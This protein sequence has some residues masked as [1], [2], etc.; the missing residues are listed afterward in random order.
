ME[1][2]D[3]ILDFLDKIGLF[4]SYAHGEQNNYSDLDSQML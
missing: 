3:E 4:G 2:R 1:T